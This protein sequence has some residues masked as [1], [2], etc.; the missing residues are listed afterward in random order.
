MA[1]VVVLNSFFKTSSEPQRSHMA[2]LRGPSLSAPPLPLRSTAE[3]AR[4]FQKREWLM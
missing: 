1:A 3:G 2:V 4:F